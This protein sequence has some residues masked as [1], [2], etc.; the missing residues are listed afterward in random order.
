MMP[1]CF[2]LFLSH[3]VVS[4]AGSK[5]VNGPA[6]QSNVLAQ[7]AFTVQFN[8]PFITGAPCRGVLNYCWR[9][10]KAPSDFPAENRASPSG[11]PPSRSGSLRSHL[12]HLLNTPDAL[13]GFLR[14]SESLMAIATLVNTTYSAPK[15]ASALVAPREHVPEK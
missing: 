11:H 7:N 10:S 9:A 4:A 14:F 2:R 12:S 13:K 1:G 15:R 6:P 8:Q 5:C 3:G